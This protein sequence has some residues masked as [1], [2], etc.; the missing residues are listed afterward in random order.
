[1]T[2]T[3]IAL[4][5][6]ATAHT[7]QATA[8]KGKCPMTRH[9]NVTAKRSHKREGCN[10]W[11]VFLVQKQPCGNEPCSR[12][13]GDRK[14]ETCTHTDH[15]P[16]PT[17]TPQTHTGDATW[18]TH[19]IGVFTPTSHPTNKWQAEGDKHTQVRSRDYYRD[20]EWNRRVGTMTRPGILRGKC[21]VSEH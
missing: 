1:M 5:L 16:I 8:E 14:L 7:L 20:G 10:L 2:P 3:L 15:I 21:R 13:S 11:S 19:E 9:G 6:V 17:P 18:A 4:A 12:K